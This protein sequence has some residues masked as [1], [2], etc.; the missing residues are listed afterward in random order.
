M[1]DYE[2][3]KSALFSLSADT[4]RQEWIEIGM[5]AKEAGLNSEDFLDWSRQSSKFVERDALAAWKSFK[6]GKG[7]GAGTLFHLA[8]AAGWKAEKT[9]VVAPTVAKERNSRSP[10]STSAAKIWQQ[11]VELSEFDT[12]PYIERKNGVKTGLR[13]VPESFPLVN[14]GVH[15]SGALV[16]PITPLGATE[17]SSL[18]FI[19]DGEL[20]S[21]W[22]A[23]ERPSKL[24]LQ[25]ASIEGVFVVGDL[26]TSARVFVTE[27][28]GQAWSCWKSTGCASVVCFGWGRV[29]RVV[30][31]IK[32][33]H[34]DVH[35]VIVP[36]AGLEDQAEQLS[37]ELRVSYVPMPKGWPRNSD[38]N[39]YARRKG[40]EAL[41]ELL[42]KPMLS[43]AATKEYPLDIVFGDQLPKQFVPPDELVEGILVQGECSMVFGDSN[44]GKTFM[45]IDMAAAISRGSNWM[46]RRT[47][48]GVVVYLATESPASVRM[49]LQGYQLQNEVELP[50][51]VIVQTPIN[52]F[53]SEDD[54]NK[55][56]ETIKLIEAKRGNKVRLIIGDTLARLSAGA[57]ENSGQDMGLVLK[58]VERMQTRCQSAMLLIHHCGKNAALGARGWSGVRAF[59]DTELEVIA[60]TTARCLEVKKQRDLNSKGVR[61]GFDLEPI[62]LGLSKWGA[63]VS[64][65]VI[66]SAAVPEATQGKRQSEVGG[67]I[68]EFLSSQAAGVKKSEVVKHFKDRHDSSSVYREIKRLVT[69]ERVHESVGIICLAK[70]VP[71]GAD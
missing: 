49:R 2:R 62:Y 45:M 4:G 15:V 38:V 39:D 60:E 5:A 61:I 54:M 42:S 13:V 52:L 8:K 69:E 27:G 56:V 32:T 71:N 55:V 46:G 21:L 23:N 34:P 31:E 59:I 36:D 9:A 48:Q 63:A 67:A 28:V 22:E 17:P 19:A 30:G 12:H 58:R 33:A 47:E 7:L 3:A 70:K 18:Q 20:A 1:T 50:D 6:P 57:N 53:D 41:E 68:V 40:L 25:G 14:A 35:I 37:E 29:R 51:F 26:S 65:C 66:R 16:V 10:K 64:T 11:C 43:A 24:N 44:S